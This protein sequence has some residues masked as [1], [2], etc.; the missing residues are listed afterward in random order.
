MEFKRIECKGHPGDDEFNGNIDLVLAPIA[1]ES[2]ESLYDQLWLM[3]S[4]GL[5]QAL[6]Y[7]MGDEAIELT[8]F[9]DDWEGGYPATVDLHHGPKGAAALVATFPVT[10]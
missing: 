9:H 1:G 2:S 6:G 3:T 5:E 10:T 4:T 8:F 7:G